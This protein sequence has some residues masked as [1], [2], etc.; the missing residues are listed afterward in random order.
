VLTRAA[1]AVTRSGTIA[2]DLYPQDW[3]F[4]AGHR[5]GLLIARSDDEWFLPPPT[6]TSVQIGGGALS[7]PFL[8]YTRSSFLP[9]H[10]TKAEEDRLPPIDVSGQIGGAEAAFDVPPALTDPPAAPLP[11][12]AKKPPRLTVALRRVDRRRVRV[13]GRAPAG[14]KLRVRVV[15]GKNRTLVTRR[16]TS[17]RRGSWRLT[18][19]VARLRG[20]VLRAVVSAPVAGTTLRVTSRRVR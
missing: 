13:S 20:R 1:Y 14:L 8:R 12:A 9:G 6:L 15:S 7:L 18:L 17:G 16:V 2:F 11:V 10:K 4:A 3:T 5:L 19:R